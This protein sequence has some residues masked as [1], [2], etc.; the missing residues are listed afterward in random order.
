M[1]TEKIILSNLIS[2]EQYTRKVLP[3]IQD[4]YFSDQSEKLIFD[5]TRSHFDQYNALPSKVEVVAEINARDNLNEAVHESALELVSGLEAV[6]VQNLDWLVDKTEAFCKEKALYNAILKCINIID[7]KDGKDGKEDKGALP[8]ILNKAL[9]VSFDTHVGHD[10]L[11][12]A[13]ARWDFYHTL[14]KKCPFDLHYFNQ[15]TK[16]GVSR[17]TLS[18][19]MCPTGG[20]KSMFMCHLAA[21]Y[22]AMGLNVLYVTMEMS[23]E[24]ISERI[25]ANL[26]NIDIGK[27]AELSKDDYLGRFAKVKGKAKGKL[28]VKEYPTGQ[29]HAGH[30]RYLLNEL[31]MKKG[32]VPDVFIVDYIGICASSR[33]KKGAVNSYDFGKAVAEEIRALAQE[34]GFAAWSAFQTNRDGIGNSEVDLKNTSESIGGPMTAD[35]LFAMVETEQL[36]ALCQ[37]MIIQLKNRYNDVNNPKK[38]VIGV[39]KAKMKFYDVEASAQNIDGGPVMDSTPSGKKSFADFE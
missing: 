32:F 31:K 5:I 26:M 15:I 16:G 38:F 3:Y 19:V 24:K 6:V 27:I 13:E 11:E 2:N 34:F 22:M 12:D 9:G 20:G 4:E 29:A 25:D 7:K 30:F 33:L 28:V 23:E 35:L 36:I 18:I 14:E 1:S 8:D 37:M 39:D 10:Y 21:S 17:K